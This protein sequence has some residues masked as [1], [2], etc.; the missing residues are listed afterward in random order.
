[1]RGSLLEL[2]IGRLQENRLRSREVSKER[3]VLSKKESNYT[4]DWPCNSIGR[5]LGVGP[6]FTRTGFGQ[7]AQVLNE[8]GS[9][10]GPPPSCPCRGA[11]EVQK[12][13]KSIVSVSQKWGCAKADLEAPI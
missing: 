12:K 2:R 3:V 7:D 5:Q 8:L 10:L 11:D 6:F 4:K 9:F 13:T 1:M